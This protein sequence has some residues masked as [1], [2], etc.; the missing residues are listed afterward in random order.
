MTLATLTDLAPLADAGDGIA[1]LIFGITN[2]VVL[3]IFIYVLLD[4]ARSFNKLPGA[5]VAAHDGLGQVC[6]PLFAPVRKVLPPMGGIDFSPVITLLVIQV[7]GRAL[8]SVF[9]G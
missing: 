1:T 8:G 4:L 6:E 7:L 2:I 3:V 5:L 9:A